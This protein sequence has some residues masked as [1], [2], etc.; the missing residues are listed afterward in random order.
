MVDA[1]KTVPDDKERVAEVAVHATERGEGRSGRNNGDGEL[2]RLS[3]ANATAP[4]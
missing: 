2:R 4:V 1:R 3:M